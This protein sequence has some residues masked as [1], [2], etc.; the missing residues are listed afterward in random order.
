MENYQYI[1]SKDNEK[2]KQIKSLENKSKRYENRLFVIEGI[3]PVLETITSSYKIKCL[4]YSKELLENINFGKEMIEKIESLDNIS[5]IETTK[6]ILEYVSSTVTS[7][8]VIAVVEMKENQ[9][10][11]DEDDYIIIDRV[12]D[13]G[14]LGTIIR[15]CDSFNIRNIIV[16][17]GTV[18]PY[19]DKVIRSTMGSILRVNIQIIEDIKP[20]ISKLKEKGYIIC[21]T[22]LN[23]KKYLTDINL[24]KKHIFVVGNEASGVSLEL[25]DLADEKIKIKMS[26]NVDSLNVSIATAIVLYSKY[27]NKG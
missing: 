26:E 8:G 23:S 17:K 2:I 15:T 7:Q 5:K 13:A 21:V 4:V 22:S 24:T 27:I 1:V 9:V 18:D 20:V 14:N 12:Q 10:M 6:Q 16:L 11:L 3:K 19:C 25:E